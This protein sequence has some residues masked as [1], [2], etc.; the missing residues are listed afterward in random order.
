M[1]II[2]NWLTKQDN[3]S[4]IAPQRDHPFVGVQPPHLVDATA[5]MQTKMT[6][7][8]PEDPEE[9]ES[10][11]KALARK[12]LIRV[13]QDVSPDAPPTN[14]RERQSMNAFLQSHKSLELADDVW[15][16]EPDILERFLKYHAFKKER[17]EHPS[18]PDEAVDQIVEDHIRG[19]NYDG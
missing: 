15:K 2:D 17:S 1:G 16:R 8:M 18:L 9:A 3:K 19:G 14:H 11:K 7:F 10:R 13:H 4:I 12:N 5:D 6:K